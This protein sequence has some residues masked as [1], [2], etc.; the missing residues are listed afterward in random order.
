[1]WLPLAGE[2][3]TEPLPAT[4][5]FGSHVRFN[6]IEYI[7]KHLRYEDGALYRTTNRGGQKVGDKVGWK[8][9]CN[10]R[11]YWKLS[12]NTK[13][14]YLHQVVFLMHHGY[15]PKYI[16]HIDGDSTNN[17]IE[18]LRP[19]TQSQ[20]CANSVMN[21]NNTSGYKGVVW[22]KRR[23]K[24]KAQLGVNGKCVFLGHFDSKEDAFEA[25]K[26]NSIKYFGEFSRPSAR[27]E[28]K[29]TL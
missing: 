2:K 13:T 29:V 9:Q 20:N 25:Y 27:Q 7:Q 28:V 21:K 19:A 24:W 5:L 4:L 14:V 15:L 10:N 1:V 6:M 3:Q 23:N 26:L 12:I 11:L 22:L 16:D 17:R 8:T 18:N